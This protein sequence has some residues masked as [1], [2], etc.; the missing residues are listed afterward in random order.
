MSVKANNFLYRR[1]RKDFPRFIYEDFSTSVDDAGLTIRY[2]FNLADRFHFH[3]QIF[4]PRK[5]F[6]RFNINES[7]LNNLAFHL[8]LVELVSY[9]KAACPPLVIVRPA[10]LTAAQIAWWK[11]LYFYGLG[12]FF[13]TNGISTTETEFMEIVAESSFNFNPFAFD[14]GGRVL[15]PVGGGKDSAVSLEM[16]RESGSPA[17][18]FIINPR[19]ASLRVSE[20]AGYARDEIFEISRTID[21]MLLELNTRGFLNGHTPFSAVV[22]FA[23]LLA[24]RLTKISR[25]ALSNESSANEATLPGTNINHQY[26]KS[27]EFE[28]DFREYV[29]RYISETYAYVSLLRPL[30]ELQIAQLFA[31]ESKYFDDFKSCN[32]GSK[33]NTWCG[34]CPKCLFT[35]IILNPFLE[36]DR[37]SKIF[38]K[39]LLE[40]ASLIRYLDELTGVAEEKPFECVGTIDEV[41]AA[42]QKALTKFPEN[43]LPI[44][45]K[46]YISTIKNDRAGNFDKLLMQFDPD[47]FLPEEFEKN[48]RKHLP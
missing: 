47:H 39:N 28:K 11:K 44:L 20:I 13:H 36:T 5:P 8:G 3:P 37:L 27:Y 46:H 35:W 43:N 29:L 31:R 19:Q 7:E 40:D 25:I 33:T 12:E 4:I 21:P 16:V 2:H 14:A 1:L 32:V 45:L 10:N 18:P 26:S 41:N 30:N 22:A 34:K 38:G 17:L 6:F 23:A 42:L 9:W 24:A 15:V 48:L